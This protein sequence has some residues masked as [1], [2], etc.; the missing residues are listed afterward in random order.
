MWELNMTDH[1]DLVKTLLE[2][3]VGEKAIYDA[4]AAIK[5]LVKE[6]AIEKGTADRALRERDEALRVCTETEML[7]HEQNRTSVKWMDRAL[8]AEAKVA[9][10]REALK[11]AIKVAAESQREWDAAPS[12]MKA[13]KLLI[14]LAGG[15]PKYRADIDEIHAALEPKP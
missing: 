2:G 1:A 6:L 5:A 7:R 4:A 15:L 14:A 11:A 13:G 9:R 3:P 12:G 10:M 8:A